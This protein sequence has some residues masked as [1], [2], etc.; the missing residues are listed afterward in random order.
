MTAM[1]KRNSQAMNGPSIPESISEQ[2]ERSPNG[3]NS[4]EPNDLSNGV[5]SPHATTEDSTPART[6]HLG[7][8]ST[9]TSS[10]NAN[11]NGWQTPPSPSRPQ[12]RTSGAPYTASTQPQNLDAVAEIVLRNIPRSA[13]TSAAA[14]QGAMG[15]GG[16]GRPIEPS[17]SAPDFRQGYNRGGNE[18]FTPEL[19]DSARRANGNAQPKLKVVTDS[20]GMKAGG[21]SQR[22]AV[23]PRGTGKTPSRRQPPAPDKP[24]P[25]RNTTTTAQ[26]STP[27]VNPGELYC[28]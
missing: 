9:P 11:A 27:V 2:S 16:G 22:S 1:N 15:G 13:S 4:S 6:S 10:A 19:R 23:D 28:S 17:R 12:R 8:A 7:A 24:R 3:R 14:G 18:E 25:R 5:Q 20:N 26:I 21:S